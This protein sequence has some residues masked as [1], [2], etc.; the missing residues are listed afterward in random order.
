M[1]RYG[2]L[3]EKIISIENL[4]LADKKARLG[5]SNK[6]GVRVHDRNKEEN[7]QKL[8]DMLVA[9]TFK[10]SSY[11]TMVIYEPKE[12]LIYKLPYYPDHILH[13]AIMNILEPI[14]VGSMTSDTYANIKGRGIHACAEKL[15]LV[16]RTNREGTMYCLKIDIRKYY[17]NIDHEILKREIRRKIKDTR[18]LNLLDGII[19]SEVGLPIGNYLS[20]Y[21]ANVYL[22]RFDHRIKEVHKAKYYFRYV[23]DMVF[24]AGTK[25][26][27][28]KLLNIIREELTELRL[29]LKDDFKVF[30]VESRG[31]DFVGYRFFH[32]YTLLRKRMKKRIFKRIGKYNKG[33]ISEDTFK[34]SMAS[35]NGWLKWSDSY[36]LREKIKTTIK[37]KKDEILLL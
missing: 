31:I 30:P 8:H 14:L 24:L 19:D 21:F 22:S 28:W 15:K 10:T 4:E 11:K 20:Q 5:K 23:D 25:E 37:S 36:R 9:G 12:R 29:E 27:L 7:I 34:K 18:L 17:P 33:K 35:Y 13:H 1:K 26:E 2:N 32:T 16:L 6:Y 3:F